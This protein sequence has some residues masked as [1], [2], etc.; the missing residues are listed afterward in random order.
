MLHVVGLNPSTANRERG[1]TTVTK[2]QRIARA[3]GYDGFV[4]TNLYP[5]RSTDP[6]GLHKRV[7]NRLLEDNLEHIAASIASVPKPVFW[8]AWGG[9]IG[10]RPYLARSLAAIIDLVADAGG[11]WVHYGSLRKDGHPRH[12]SRAAYTLK[13]SRF[14]AEHYLA[15]LQSPR[16]G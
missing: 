9:D 3:Q 10:S 15:S 11:D 6:K 16:G 12:P 14:D 8:A 7:N 1:D 4:M 2:T 5:M 13:F